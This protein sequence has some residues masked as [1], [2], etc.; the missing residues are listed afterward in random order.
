MK[1]NK[2]FPDTRD[3]F[4]VHGQLTAS[5]AERNFVLPIQRNAIDAIG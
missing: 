5:I 4:F 1:V 2:L 3:A